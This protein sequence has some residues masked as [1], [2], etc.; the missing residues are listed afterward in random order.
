LT[1]SEAFNIVIRAIRATPQDVLLAM[2]RKALDDAANETCVRYPQ[3]QW[4]H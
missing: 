3:P 2:L 1:E 4:I